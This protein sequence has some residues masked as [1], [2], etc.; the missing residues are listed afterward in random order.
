MAELITH[1]LAYARAQKGWSQSDLVEQLRRAA[2]RRPQG[3][4]TGADKSA[5][6]RWE[7]GRKTPHL[8][9][10]LLLADVF[11]VPYE[12]VAQFGWPHWLPGRHEP[13]PVA[14]GHTVTSLRNALRAAMDPRRRTFMAFG[15]FALA[16]LAAQ[17]A[18]LEPE[19][20][21]AALDG[22]RVDGPLLD[23]LEETSRTLNALPTEQRQ[24]TARLMDAQLATVTDLIDEG[25]YSSTTGLRLHRL[26]ASLAV[27]C[28][29]YRFDQGEHHLAG[30]LWNAALVNAH[31][32]RDRDLGAGI[33]S[34]FAYQAIW[35]NRP[36]DAIAPLTQALSRAA[37]PTA[38][39]LLYLRRA[40]GHAALGDPNACHRD[41]ASAE[42]ALLTDTPDPAP[43]WCVWMGPADLAV[44]SGQCLLDLGRATEALGRI[45]E[46]IGLLPEARAKTRAVF[47]LSQAR[48]LLMAREVEQ[49]LK[50]TGAAL[51]VATRIGA[52]RCAIQAKELA[53]A[54]RPHRQVEGV[55]ELLVRLAA[56]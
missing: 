47:Q 48:G 20:L 19:R 12:E 54:F 25:N 36:G 24:R 42:T 16:G 44:D 34:D 45:D 43:A 27:T 13:F 23:W 3:L 14:A 5:V 17:W 55:P 8:E 22:K 15:A 41:L 40:R 9:S 53:P 56:V 33:L 35:Q 1:P 29:W 7:N 39:S 30:Q 18:E 38:R 51:D 26:A 10:Q 50:T 28:G 52:Q 2:A 31:A 49:A 4:R 21:D 11:G 46:G 6:S 37:H 32:G